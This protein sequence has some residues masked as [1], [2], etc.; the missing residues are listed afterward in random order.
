MFF[1]LIV[2]LFII[3]C[4]ML[5]FLFFWPCW[6]YIPFL[7]CVGLSIML[8]LSVTL[9]Y[10]KT[11]QLLIRQLPNLCNHRLIDIAEFNRADK[12]IMRSLEIMQITSQLAKPYKKSSTLHETRKLSITQLPNLFHSR[13]IDMADFNRAHK[14]SMRNLEI[15]QITSQ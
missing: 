3:F 9:K 10:A 2:I 4:I 12:K 1:V 5:Y 14:K 8:I 7:L 15:K 11:R 13:I 6:H